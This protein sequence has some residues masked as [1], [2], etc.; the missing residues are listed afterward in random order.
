MHSH[1]IFKIQEW[2]YTD[3]LLYLI[4]AQ[5]SL[6]NWYGYSKRYGAHIQNKH[7]CAFP[8]AFKGGQSQN[9]AAYESFIFMS[10]Q[11]I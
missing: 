11:D 2:N 7:M 8:A 4:Y 3:T 6:K 5:E 10:V 1:G 9:Q